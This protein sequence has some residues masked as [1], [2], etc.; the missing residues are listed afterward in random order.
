MPSAK[1]HINMNFANEQLRQNKYDI[2]ALQDGTTINLY[3]YENKWHMASA[4]GISVND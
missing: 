3:Y 2:Y 1:T 4:R